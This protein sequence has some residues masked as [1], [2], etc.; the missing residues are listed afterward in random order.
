MGYSPITAYNIYT[1]DGSA[2]GNKIST[3]SLTQIFTGLTKG[4]TYLYKVEAENVFGPSTQFAT[5]S[6]TAA[7]KPG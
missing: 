4:N 2:W 7:D 3:Q 6:V 1:W 5:I